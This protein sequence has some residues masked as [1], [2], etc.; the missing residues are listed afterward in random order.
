MTRNIKWRSCQ[1]S[2]AVRNG[3]TPSSQQKKQNDCCIEKMLDSPPQRPRDPDLVQLEPTFYDVLT[4]LL[5]SNQTRLVY[6]IPS[7]RSSRMLLDMT[8]ARASAQKHCCACCVLSVALPQPRHV[9][10]ECFVACQLARLQCYRQLKPLLFEKINRPGS[11]SKWENIPC[12]GREREQNKTWN[13]LSLPP[14]EKRGTRRCKTLI[15]TKAMI[16]RDPLLKLRKARCA[17]SFS[18]LVQ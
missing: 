8:L 2:T 5:S 18:L 7:K 11:S 9:R 4:L 16:D 10:R 1:R 6:R 14:C 3:W 15:N 13:S 12:C 17:S